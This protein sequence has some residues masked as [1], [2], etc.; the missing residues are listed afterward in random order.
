MGSIEKETKKNKKSRSAL[1]G[2]IE[3]STKS[4]KKSNS[5]EKE[6]KK[7]KKSKK[8][9]KKNRSKSK[10]R[11]SSKVS[12]SS[13]SLKS[14]IKSEKATDPQFYVTMKPTSSKTQKRGR[15][16]SP[17]AAT[18]EPSLNQVTKALKPPK[19]TGIDA[20]DL[21]NAMEEE[22]KKAAETKTEK[23]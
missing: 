7:T 5:T 16:R 10:E 22:A 1:P 14:E 20:L 8:S 15:S 9:K 13:K 19:T 17:T 11:K 4:R 6:S 12:V 23:L 21:L 2:P 3:K 18:D